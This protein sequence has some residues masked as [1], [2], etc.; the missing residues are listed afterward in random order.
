VEAHN[1]TIAVDSD[2]GRGSTFRICLPL[3]PLPAGHGQGE[4][5][6]QPVWVIE[7]GLGAAAMG[8]GDRGDDGEPEAG[9]GQSD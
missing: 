7:R 3:W 6:T 8:S 1:G 2:E 5:D 4:G 9:P